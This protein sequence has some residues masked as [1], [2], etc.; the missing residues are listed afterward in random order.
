MFN[1]FSSHNKI[2]KEQIVLEAQEWL[3]YARQLIAR[4]TASESRI[5][6]Q[7][8]SYVESS[9]TSMEVR[10]YTIELK[11]LPNS[12][13]DSDHAC[14]FIVKT[15]I[16]Q[17]LLRAFEFKIEK[18]KTYTENS[19]EI[20]NESNFTKQSAENIFNYFETKISEAYL[21]KSVAIIQDSL[22][23]YNIQE[24]FISDISEK[25]IEPDKIILERLKKYFDKHGDY[26]PNL[27][28]KVQYIERQYQ[29]V[30]R[31]KN[32]VMNNLE[33]ERKDRENMIKIFISHSS[34]DKELVSK[35]VE[36]FRASLNIPSKE[37]RCTSLDGYRLPGGA[38]FND[39]L[40]QEVYDSHVFIGV[41]SQASFQSQYVL[42]ELGA[43]WGA[44][45][46]LIPLLAPDMSNDLV[47]DPL[48]S[49][50]ALRCDSNSQL[51]Q[52][53]EELSELL[54]IKLD[55]QSAY[56]KYID[57]IVSKKP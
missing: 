13:P 8:I 53:I 5:L 32:E 29:E 4:I 50:N 30:Q 48:K 46:Q 2:N 6:Q 56:Q 26:Y 27:C 31:Q 44:K 1:F 11:D 39:Q 22:R 12:F 33:Y 45:K 15:F 40:R 14:T 19:I 25:L 42:F 9:L 24:R 18:L 23:A 43:R 36:L 37:I 55:K 41:L 21:T 47:K 10:N 34:S 16:L 7:N 38:N 52:L 20:K 51:V 28:K 49:L 35:L 3:V 54:N 17:V 57:A